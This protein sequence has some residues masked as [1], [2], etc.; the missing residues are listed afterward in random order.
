MA[1]ICPFLRAKTSSFS[2]RF[3]TL[4]SL[5]TFVFNKSFSSFPLF[6]TS[7]P[8]ILVPRY[9]DHGF[10]VLAFGR[11]I[12]LAPAPPKITPRPPSCRHAMA[13][14]REALGHRVA[15]PYAP[16]ADTG[17]PTPGGFSLGA[18][19]DRGRSFLKGRDFHR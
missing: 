15:C 13:C 11:L 17:D 16:K 12:R 1:Y 14:R 10:R 3:C 9:W 8:Q 7:F 18:V 4:R 19:G 2:V 5:T 6:L